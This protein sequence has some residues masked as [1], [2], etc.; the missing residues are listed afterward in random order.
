MFSK[1]AYRLADRPVSLGVQGVRVA[2]ILVTAPVIE[3][4]GL[5]I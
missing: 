4:S 2:Y 3:E 5:P 1:V